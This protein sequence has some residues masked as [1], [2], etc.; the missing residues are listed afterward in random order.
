M[1]ENKIRL[2]Q[3]NKADIS[4]YVTDI[5][6]AGVQVVGSPGAT[7]P[8]GAISTG[9]TGPTGPQI[10]G[11]T[12]PTGAGIAGPTGG[13]GAVGP[14][15]TRGPAGSTGAT[16]E[17]ATGP[18]GPQGAPGAGSAAA[19]SDTQIQYNHAGTVA[20]SSNFVY[21]YSNQTVYADGANLKIGKTG[22][23]ESQKAA[24]KDAYMYVDGT[25][26]DLIIRKQD[27]NLQFIIDGDLGNVGIHLPTGTVPAYSLDVSGEAYFRG[28]SS[29]ALFV[30]HDTNGTNLVV[31]NAAGISKSKISSYT[32][33][34][35]NG[36]KVGINT[37]PT[38]STF[39]QLVVN[40]TIS[41]SGIAV[42]HTDAAPGGGGAA[43]SQGEIRYD[44]A[45]LYICVATDT[46]KK[47]AL[48][49][50]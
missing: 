44:S 32:N 8:T 31:K 10:V 22:I 17:P 13:D 18:T 38:D 42:K 35:I 45:N 34:W 29:Q 28:D 43:G 41:C 49:T 48:S 30:D 37:Y 21:S 50:F 25:Y 23:I 14:I 24:G 12:G 2:S 6:T 16:G 9:P 20:G 27:Q 39:G 4:G 19:G 1:A 15:G 46:W 40:G 5:I 33:S 26:D 7:V 11:P 3:M 47:V 36:G